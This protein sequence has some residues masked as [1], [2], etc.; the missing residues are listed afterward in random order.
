M[1]QSKKN[2][3]WIEETLVIESKRLRFLSQNVEFMS[4]YISKIKLFFSRAANSKEY[5]KMKITHKN[6]DF[7][8]AVSND[9]L[10][11]DVPEYFY[12]FARIVQDKL[13]LLGI[14]PKKI[15]P[16]SLPNI[17]NMKDVPESVRNSCSIFGNILKKSQVLGNW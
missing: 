4:A 10:I 13:S 5:Y 2:M 3:S 11:E 15:D 8:F 9:K 12:V 16:I 6:E 1:V 7:F 17:M 14:E